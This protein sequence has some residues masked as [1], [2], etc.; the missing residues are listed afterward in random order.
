MSATRCG[1]S[2]LSGVAL[3]TCRRSCLSE[4]RA[5]LQAP[6]SV[7]ITPVATLRATFGGKYPYHEK[8]FPYETKKYN[9]FQ[10]LVD[11]CLPRFNENSKIIVVEGN[12][13]VGKTEFAK[14]FAK[15]YDL[16]FFPSTS[17][18]EC[19]TCND[20]SFDTRGLDPLLPPEA[21]SYDLAKFLADEH[22][23]KGTV[24]RLQ[25]M[26]YQ[27]KFFNYARHMKHLL[28]TGQGVVL[29][30]SV[31]SDMVFVEAL[32]RMGWCTPNFA[33]YYY[34][35]RDNS[36]CE[37]FKPHLTI[38]LDAPISVLRERINKRND[39]R[40]VNSRQLTDN[41]LQTISD[42]YQ[43]KYL[44]FAR[45][46]GEV[47][48]IDWTDIANEEDMDVIIEEVQSVKL[49]SDDLDAKK[50]SDW[51]RLDED[52]FVKMRYFLD[53]ETLLEAGFSRPHPWNAPEAMFTQDA[54]VAFQKIRDNHPAYKYPPG[55]SPELG[56]NTLFKF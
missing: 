37:F 48:E 43:Q 56:H 19:F 27:Q 34:D 4:G 41:Y 18:R 12:I 17:D 42:V 16:K 9:W 21:Q 36:I 33:K 50:F 7:N 15:G 25:L 55:W 29:T 14:R 49:E 38:Y 24:G 53:S 46:Y 5:L 8:P 20:Y 35:Y 28:S 30:R 1:Y 32:L 26:W 2:R 52:D 40:E 11:S 51:N 6:S 44:P 22:P 39:P 47:V 54:A 45:A 3:A 13:G 23:E 31:Y 10:T